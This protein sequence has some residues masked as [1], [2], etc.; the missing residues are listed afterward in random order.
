M[1]TFRLTIARSV[2]MARS[3]K[4]FWYRC[5]GGRWWIIGSEMLYQACII[6]VHDSNMLGDPMHFTMETLKI[7]SLVIACHRMS[8]VIQR[9]A[10]AWSR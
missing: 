8:S 3:I 9:A 4:L 7:W 5:Y 1:A 10:G 6:L 2:R